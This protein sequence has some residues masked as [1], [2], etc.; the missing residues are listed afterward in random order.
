MSTISFDPKMLEALVCPETHTTL[1]YDADKQELVSKRAN[2][3]FPIRDGI[4]VMLVD[5]ARR[6]D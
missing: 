6:L 5:E 3:A 1:S 2:L 4:P